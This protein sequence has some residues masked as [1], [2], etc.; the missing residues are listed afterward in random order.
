MK[1]CW[2]SMKYKPE[3][4]F[5]EFALET[6]KVENVPDWVKKS[7]GRGIVAVW[8]CLLEVWDKISF[9]GFWEMGGERR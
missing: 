4:A 9:V 6:E 7:E 3:G 8:K 1:C 2:E 5:G